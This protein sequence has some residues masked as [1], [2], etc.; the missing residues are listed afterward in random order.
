MASISILV[1]NANATN[2]LQTVNMVFQPEEH[3][4]RSGGRHDI[5]HPPPDIIFIVLQS[6]LLVRSSCI[7]KG[8]APS[9]LSLALKFIETTSFPLHI[10]RTVY[11]KYAV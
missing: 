10:K 6:R 11:F 7:E 9:C 1:E 4:K 8:I 3:L 2:V 5:L